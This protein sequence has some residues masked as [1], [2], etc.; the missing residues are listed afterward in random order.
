MENNTPGMAKL[1]MKNLL[2]ENGLLSSEK[3]NLEVIT[4]DEQSALYTV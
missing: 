1:A 4:Q 3:V 2:E